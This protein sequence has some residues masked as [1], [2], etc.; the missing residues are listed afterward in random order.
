MAKKKFDLQIEESRNTNRE[1]NKLLIK[2][3]SKIQEEVKRE[4]DKREKEK[5]NK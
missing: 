4:L 2:T 1:T 3:S 5:K